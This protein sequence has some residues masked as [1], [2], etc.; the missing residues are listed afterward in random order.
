[1]H[2][3]LMVFHWHCDGRFISVHLKT[4]PLPHILSG[5]GMSL[6]AMLSKHQLNAYMVDTVIVVSEYSV[7]SWASCLEYPP[8]AGTPEVI[9][10]VEQ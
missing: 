1:M 10:K 7:R 3:I 9:L 8:V 2:L 5:L 6:S 4:R